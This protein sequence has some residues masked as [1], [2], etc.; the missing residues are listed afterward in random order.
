MEKWIFFNFI[1]YL[2]LSFD[3]SEM[4]T[5]KDIEFIKLLTNKATTLLKYQNCSLF[6]SNTCWSMS[7]RIKISSIRPFL[8][9]LNIKIIS[10]KCLLSILMSQNH[11]IFLHILN[12]C[13]FRYAFL[14][15]VVILF[16]CLNKIWCTSGRKGGR[17]L[18]CYSF[19]QSIFL[20]K[21]WYFTYSIP[22]KP[23]LLSGFLWMSLFTK[24]ML[25]LD[26]P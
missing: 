13:I 5:D 25:S 3:F 19:S 9:T 1:V 18:R 16:N 15:V 10:H 23:S 14:I 21:G 22:L 24:S 6:L 7:K 26:Q 12:L 2:F 4:L 11:F 20:K 8:G 17:I